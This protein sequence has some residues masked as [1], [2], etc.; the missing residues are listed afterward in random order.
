ME[1]EDKESKEETGGG[2]RLVAGATE[3]EEEVNLDMALGVEV[4]SKEEIEG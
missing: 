1:T 3:E 4:K 2:L